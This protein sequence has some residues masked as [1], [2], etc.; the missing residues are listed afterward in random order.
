MKRWFIRSV[1]GHRSNR[2]NRSN[3]NGRSSRR[4]CA[5][6]SVGRPGVNQIV[7]SLTARGLT[8]GGSR[9]TW[10]QVYGAQFSN[11]AAL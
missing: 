1:L 8:T 6:V 7:L 10:R 11:D 3:R 9:R 2:S 5:S 4:W